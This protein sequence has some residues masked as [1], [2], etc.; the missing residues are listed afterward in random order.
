MNNNSD[1]NNNSKYLKSY[2][3]YLIGV[4]EIGIWKKI[5]WEERLLYLFFKMNYIWN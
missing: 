1:D 2:K 5:N 3:K 4:E